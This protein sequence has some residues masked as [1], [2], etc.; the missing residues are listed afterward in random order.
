MKRKPIHAVSTDYT[1]PVTGRPRIITVCGSDYSPNSK[2]IAPR[3]DLYKLRDAG[4][5]VC[6]VCSR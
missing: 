2:L 1:D 4:E 3:G 5:P 6:A